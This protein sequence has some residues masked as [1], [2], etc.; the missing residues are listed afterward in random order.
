MHGAEHLAVRL[1]DIQLRDLRAVPHAHIFE[2]ERDALCICLQIG[3]GKGGIAQP[4]PEREADRYIR[5]IKVAVSDIQSLAVFDGQ[6]LARKA[7]RRRTVRIAHGEGLRKLSGRID[8]ARQHIEHRPRPRLTRETGIYDSIRIRNRARIHDA[9][10]GEDN[11]DPFARRSQAA[12]L[13][14]LRMMQKSPIE[15]W[16]SLTQ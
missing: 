6:L 4:E 14:S 3:I 8:P 15:L 11:G 7:R 2:R 1:A 9:P 16:R 10:A 12:I 5:R 13:P